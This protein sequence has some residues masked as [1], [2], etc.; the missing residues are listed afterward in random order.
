MMIVTI[1]KLRD[2]SSFKNFIVN[3]DS[4]VNRFVLEFDLILTLI[5]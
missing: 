2:G 1:Q 3:C 4:D 5:K